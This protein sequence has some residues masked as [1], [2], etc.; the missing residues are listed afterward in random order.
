MNFQARTIEPQPLRR[1]LQWT[2]SLLIAAPASLMVCYGL[3]ALL[4]WVLAVLAVTVA[5]AMPVLPVIVAIV[6]YPVA[7]LAT[8]LV[9]VVVAQSTDNAQSVRDNLRRWP[10]VCPPLSVIRSASAILLP[11]LVCTL[12]LTS[13]TLPSTAKMPPNLAAV[14]AINSML[15]SAVAHALFALAFHLPHQGP[16]LIHQACAALYGIP[17]SVIPGLARSAIVKNPTLQLQLCGLYMIV[18]ASIGIPY[19]LGGFFSALLL[20]PLF[21]AA[22]GTLSYVIL[23]DIYRG[24]RRRKDEATVAVPDA[25]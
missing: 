16:R 2:S 8:Q 13:T 3:W 12:L 22:L 11:I 6:A 14:S 4:D 21:H 23:T 10:L 15:L 1:W 20:T 9:F 5:P 18:P 24:G 17:R 19:L 7:G 25:S